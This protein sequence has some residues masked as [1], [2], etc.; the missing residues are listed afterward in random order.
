M[1]FF[2]P[3]LISFEEGDIPRKDLGAKELMKAGAIP[4]DTVL[5]S[6]RD[7]VKA[8]V[9]SHCHL[10]HVGAVPFIA[11]RY[12][13]DVVGTPFTIE[14]LKQIINDSPNKKSNPNKFQNKFQE[15]QRIQQN[16]RNPLKLWE[17]NCMC[18]K[19]NHFHGTD[20][21]ET[22]FKTTYSPERQEIIY[23]EKCYQQE[24]Y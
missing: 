22:E 21:C 5:E 13:A 20:K 16:L 6:W 7:K 9:F 10:D 1:G 17:G 11:Q 8:I 12:K 14:V 24:I 2:L 4:D 18:N 19:E 15:G 23:C 3:K